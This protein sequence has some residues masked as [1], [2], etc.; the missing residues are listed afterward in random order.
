MV[1]LLLICLMFSSPIYAAE[2][3]IQIHSEEQGI[4]YGKPLQLQ[5]TAININAPI[6]T[7]HLKPLLRNFSMEYLDKDPGSLERQELWLRLYPRRSGK[8]TVPTLQLNNVF[9]QPL[10]LDVKP[11]SLDNGII[12]VTSQLDKNKVWQRQQTLLTLEILSP[13]QFYSL[14]VDKPAIQGFDLIAIPAQKK[15]LRENGKTLYQTRLGWVLLPLSADDYQISIPGIRY[16]EGGWTLY[17]FHTPQLHVTV[18]RLP[19]YVGPNIVVGRLNYSLAD[20][21]GYFVNTRNTHHLSYVLRGSGIIEEWLPR[22]DD[23]FAANGSIQFYPPLY[24]SKLSIDSDGLHSRQ[25][26]VIPFRSES[27]AWH[28]IPALA[29]QYFDPD[30]GKLQTTRVKAIRVFIYSPTWL[31]TL[32]ALAGVILISQLY[33]W[34]QRLKQSWRGM[35]LRKLAL[36]QIQQASS[37][38]HLMAAIKA[39]SQACGLHPNPSMTQLARAWKQRFH[40]DPVLEQSLQRLNQL[41]YGNA[42]SQPEE[43]E[44]LTDTLYTRFKRVRKLWFE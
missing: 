25:N 41:Y 39:Y 40:L 6:H 21:P 38:A 10:E 23:Q 12:R 35:R 29:T 13:Q 27:F 31:W 1:A 36:R 15:T 20:A 19:S 43:F 4:V 44:R 14:D 42:P 2:L 18:K 9:S 8:V 5:I 37:L 7:I 28:Q 24:Q 16:I 30:S 11:A 34:R 17:E 26:V 32:C 33:R 22:I 3:D